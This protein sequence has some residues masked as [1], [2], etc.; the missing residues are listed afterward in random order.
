MNGQEIDGGTLADL[1]RELLTE[2]DEGATAYLRQAWLSTAMQAL[3]N[4]RRQANLT[5]EEMARRLKTTQSAVAR[6]ES[7]HEGR[8]SLHR[9]VDYLQSCDAL[10]L[11]IEI[12]PVRIVRQYVLAN[13]E[14]PCTSTAYRQWLRARTG[15]T[16]L[17][18]TSTGQP[19]ASAAPI[20]SG[21]LSAASIPLPNSLEA[22]E[23]PLESLRFVLSVG[24][25]SGVERDVS[26]V[27]ST[28]TGSILESECEQEL[29]AA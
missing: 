22:V 18:S 14:A 13:P 8:L 17:L 27:Y 1:T 23:R 16:T 19:A 10:P 11:D 7:D 9:Y 2:S 15:E 29:V 26:T 3:R 4:A 6:L 25:S 28:S 21:L 20:A 5:Q 12:A 24:N